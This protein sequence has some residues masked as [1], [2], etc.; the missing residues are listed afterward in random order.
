MFIGANTPVHEI[1]DAIASIQPNLV[2]ISIT[3]YYHLTQLRKLSESLD[4]KFAPREFKL[5][6]GGYAVNS[7]NNVFKQLS[8]DHFIASF[9]DLKDVKEGLL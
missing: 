5:A 8:V 1:E 9:E 3:S 2:C 6:I 4:A 7:S